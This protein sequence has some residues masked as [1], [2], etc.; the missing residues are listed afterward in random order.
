MDVIDSSKLAL[1]TGLR[2]PMSI[3]Y[4]YSCIAEDA[5]RVCVIYSWSQDEFIADLNRFFAETEDEYVDARSGSGEGC[6]YRRI[7]RAQMEAL[8]KSLERPVAPPEDP[9]K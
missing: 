7:T 2:V 3:Q 4:S 6:Y 1:R 5:N 9:P 8:K